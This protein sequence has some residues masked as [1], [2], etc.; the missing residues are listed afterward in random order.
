MRCPGC[1]WED[2]VNRFIRHKLEKL[3]DEE[4]P[5][6]KIK[7]GGIAHLQCPKCGREFRRLVGFP[8]RRFK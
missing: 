6:E 8:D 4:F 2:D 5:H 7:T 1:W 3:K